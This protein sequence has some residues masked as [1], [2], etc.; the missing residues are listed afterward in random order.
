MRS[1]RI[2]LST[3]TRYRDRTKKRMCSVPITSPPQQT[4]RV[5]GDGSPYFFFFFL[6]C[7]TPKFAPFLQA[8]ATFPGLPSQQ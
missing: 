3:E 1:N 7:P 2:G 8:L 4:E 6:P 5:R